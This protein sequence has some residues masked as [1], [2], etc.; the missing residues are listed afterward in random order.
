M[1]AGVFQYFKERINIHAQQI[2]DAY[3][4]D[5]EEASVEKWQ[6]LFGDAF[7]VP[8]TRSSSTKF[9]RAGAADRG[10]DTGRTGRAG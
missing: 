9:G 4:E 2:R 10:H 3:D 5:D 6:E 1:E 7:T 8:E